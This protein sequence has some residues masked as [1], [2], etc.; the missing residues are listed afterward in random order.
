[1]QHKKEHGAFK[2]ALGSH[3][4]K[5]RLQKGMSQEALASGAG[6]TRATVADI[7]KGAANPGIESVARIADALGIGVSDL[8]SERVSHQSHYIIQPTGGTLYDALTEQLKA[9][10]NGELYIQAAYSK[11]S[12]VDLLTAAFK[13]FR[14]SGGKLRVLTGIDQHNT[15]AEALYKLMKL[16]DSVYVVHDSA[17]AQTYHSKIYTVRTKE[18]AWVAVGSN[19]LT[20]GGLYTNYEACHTQVL[21]M[22]DKLDWCEFKAITDAF[23]EYEKSELIKSITCTED[24]QQLLSDGLIVT[25]QQSRQYAARRS[26]FNSKTE[27][28]H[29]SVSKL[30]PITEKILVPSRL[31]TSNADV[32][33]PSTK[34][35]NGSQVTAD[36]FFNLKASADLQETYWFEMRASTGGSRNILDL[37]STAKLQAGTHPLAKNNVIPG[38]VTFFE[39]D[40]KSH[41][42]TKNITVVY[43]GIAYFPSTVKF[44]P[45]NASWRIQLKGTA[46]TGGESLA[47]FG[48]TDFADHILVF[49]KVTP[50]HYIL[51]TMAGSELDALKK[52]SEF[53]ATNGSSKSSKAFGKIKIGK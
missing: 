51:E 28:G 11:S 32:Q 26:D 7:E 15:T 45:N 34:I 53:W 35:T 36:S 37:S 40:P 31:F 46:E 20:R 27:F 49:H 50:D 19:N 21:D 4:Q 24:I 3:I 12:G 52:S 17:F 5:A 29:R 9:A 13:S 38:S 8:F 14:K 48:R 25:E 18:Q 30:P 33:K 22:S 6:L 2:K 43:N 16:C 10:K 42:S 47:Q 1:M 41:G 44:A 39:T 23:S